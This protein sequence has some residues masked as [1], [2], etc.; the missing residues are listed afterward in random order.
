MPSQPTPAP[1]DAPSPVSSRPRPT[2]TSSGQ[3]V[4]ERRRAERTPIE[5]DVSLH[6]E[7]R[8]FAGFT[9]NLS[10]HGA[11]I[12]THLVQ[13]VD[14]LVRLILH[15]DECAI[16]AVGEVRWTRDASESGNQPPGMGIRFVAVEPGGD[17]VLRR[18]LDEHGDVD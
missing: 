3:F 6:T 18:L 9:E 8:Y 7:T 14:T 2:G 10:P 17:E 16:G 1:A 12:A 4:A 13:K 5:L 11:F 15:L